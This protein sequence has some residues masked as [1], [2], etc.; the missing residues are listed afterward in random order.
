MFSRRIKMQYVLFLGQHVVLL[1][2]IWAV[3]P[4]IF[5]YVIAIALSQDEH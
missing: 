4:D 1:E 3:L 2:Y 5:K